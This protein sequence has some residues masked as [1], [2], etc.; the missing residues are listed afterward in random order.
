MD[1][2]STT[3]GATSTGETLT[4]IPQS[5]T[6][7]SSEPG[8]LYDMN[9][10]VGQLA[11]LD[12]LDSLEKQVSDIKDSLN[13]FHASIK[14][15]QDE[16]D[17]LKSDLKDCK[18]D[19]SALQDTV[20]KLKSDL[21][22]HKNKVKQMEISIMAQDVQSRKLNVIIDG[23][24][25]TEGENL[26]QITLSVFSHTGK[27]YTEADIDAVYRVG[28]NNARKP[29]III[30]RLYKQHQRDEILRNRAAI[31]KNAMYKNVWLNDD[32]PEQVRQQRAELRAIYNLARTKGIEARVAQ[33]FIVIEGAKYRHPDLN[34]LPGNL[35][36]KAAN[37]RQTTKG[38][39]FHSKHAVCS[40]FYQSTF[41]FDDITYNSVE[42]AFQYSRALAGNSAV[43]AH[44][45]LCEK[46]PLAV[47]R[48]G[49]SVKPDK[50]WEDTKRELMR[51]LV[52]E[53]FRQNEALI[54]E[55]VQL[56]GDLIEATADRYWGAG[57]SL[58]SS[59]LTQ[60]NWTG[61]NHLGKILTEIRDSFL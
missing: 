54:A 14:Y 27:S 26:L 59:D 56:H 60:G 61:Q 32:I 48:L 51:K 25:E 50:K 7:Q 53:K 19:N 15:T 23:L 47:K 20:S 1:A 13:S 52:Y 45:I 22:A 55:L 30:V 3:S 58:Y 39:A 35:S 9:F 5:N 44:H 8:H 17:N 43:I 21:E 2:Q 31:K 37:T 34:S 46:D 6:P 24:N 28:S 38:T 49:S 57:V 40:N 12:K 11:K 36:L 4:V 10:V 18:K 33:D 41:T 16:V 29:R 42:Q